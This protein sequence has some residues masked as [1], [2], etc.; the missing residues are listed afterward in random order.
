MFWWEPFWHAVFGIGAQAV[1]LAA[2]WGLNNHRHRLARRELEARVE[3]RTRELNRVNARLMDAERIAHLGHWERDLLTGTGFWSEEN[4]RI[5]GL[6]PELG[7]PPQERF[8][9]CIHPEDRTALVRMSIPRPRW[10]AMP[11]GG[12]CA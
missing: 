12:R 8:L 4:F 11:K 7:S 6:A 10:C 9:S 2:L 5:Y 1:L 3:E